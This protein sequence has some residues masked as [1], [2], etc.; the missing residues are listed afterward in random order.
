MA[1][2]ANLRVISNNRAL[3]PQKPS[4]RN[5]AA[6]FFLRTLNLRGSAK[7]IIGHI[8]RLSD[9]RGF[10]E[11]KRSSIA[12]LA[13]WSDATIDRALAKHEALGHIY[14]VPQKKGERGRFSNP[15]IVILYDDAAKDLAGSLGWREGSH[16][17]LRNTLTVAQIAA[18]TVAHFGPST[19]AQIAKD[20]VAQIAPRS[21]AEQNK[22]TTTCAMTPH[23]RAN[24][25][26]L[27]SNNKKQKKSFGESNSSDA[28]LA[29]AWKNFEQV[30]PDEG[31]AYAK[32][33]VSFR[34]LSPG[35]RS[36]AIRWVLPFV[37][38]QSREKHCLGSAARYLTQQLWE[39]LQ[40]HQGQPSKSRAEK[41]IIWEGEANFD[42]W[43]ADWR[44]KHGTQPLFVW[45]QFDQATGRRGRGILRPTPWPPGHAMP[46]DCGVAESQPA[47]AMW[48]LSPESE[49][50]EA[51]AD[52][53]DAPS[54][55]TKPTSSTANI[56]EE[57]LAMTANDNRKIEDIL[58]PQP[59]ADIDRLG[60]AAAAFAHGRRTR[61][62]DDEL[63]PSQRRDLEFLMSLPIEALT[64]HPNSMTED[65]CPAATDACL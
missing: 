42:A 16:L 20:T 43:S 29:E 11:Y 6:M 56:F 31:E 46:D 62:R 5:D 34:K 61:I 26:S 59:L 4:V 12:R 2:R 37:A 40:R 65:T 25:D 10:C 38:Q 18:S 52:L 24:L 15:A 51:D 3:R 54:V 39:P 60:R 7:M 9:E 57:R 21:E 41:L 32:A 50:D 44:V 13:G 30:W 53:D 28:E 36:L 8:A 35:Q 19:V 1:D 45:D 64:I 58:G 63:T 49:P 23:A 55:E 14:R 27:D 33:R 48:D 17:T 22:K 47:E